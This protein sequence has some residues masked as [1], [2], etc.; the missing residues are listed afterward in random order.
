VTTNDF[1]VISNAR[2]KQLEEMERE[3]TWL[4]SRVVEIT[5][6]DAD[7]YEAELFIGGDTLD[8]LVFAINAERESDEWVAAQP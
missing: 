7:G 1:S 3:L 4:A 2:L 8:A 6:K 5:Y